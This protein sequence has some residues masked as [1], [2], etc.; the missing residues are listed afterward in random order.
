MVTQDGTPMII[1]DTIDRS[2]GSNYF[3]KLNIIII[4]RQKHS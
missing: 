4:I 2:Y 1:V 3:M